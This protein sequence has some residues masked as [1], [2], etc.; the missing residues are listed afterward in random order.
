VAAPRNDRRAPAAAGTFYPADGGEL[1]RDVGERL[2][3]AART[4]RRH[5]A[6]MAPHAG[7]VYSG[8]VAAHAFADTEVPA[9]VVVLAPNH[10]G[11]GRRGAVWD[12]G[13]FAMPGGDIPV[14][15][16]LCAALLDG[17]L[18]S[19]HAAHR[20]EHALEVELPFLRARRPDV[21]VSP[22]VLGGF[23][24]DEC[25][26]IGERLARVI[27]SLDEDVLVVASS[28]MNHY[29]D[30]ATTRTV[31]RRA[32][33]PLLRLDARG[34]FERVRDEDISMC[35]V[36]PATTMLAYANAR[37]ATRATL[38]AYGTSADAFGDT[39]RCVGYA[40]VVID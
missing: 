12:H 7:Y 19:D 24:A 14:D 3:R 5:L 28:D 13:A 18:V 31:D 17:Q 37:G 9:R 15:E 10:T 26:R 21:R 6:L 40:A 30:D 2:A 36:L 32:L 20:D 8:D 1:Y 11:S 34:L 16:E 27:T 29:L 38:V 23:D 25:V 39:R 35:G 4:P 33:E 22:I